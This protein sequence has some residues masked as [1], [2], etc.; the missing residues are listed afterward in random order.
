[1]DTP[2]RPEGST[3]R[4]LAADGLMLLVLALLVVKF[5]WDIDKVRDVALA[6]ETVYLHSGYH[7]LDRGFPAPAFSPLYALWYFLLSCLEPDPLRLYFLSWSVLTFL[8]AAGVY[9]L[10]RSLGGTRAAGLTAGFL[11]LTSQIPEVSPYP[12]YLATVLLLFGTVLAIR[13]RGRAASVAVLAATLLLTAFVRPEF[14]FAF[15]LLAA[16]G[17]GAGLW[18]A[19]R[20]PAARFPLLKAAFPVVLAAAG[21]VALF[22]NPFGGARSFIAFGQHYARN[23]LL[24]RHDSEPPWSVWES[25]V[26]GDFG[27]AHSVGA[28]VRNNPRAFAWHVGSNVCTLPRQGLSLTIPQLHVSQRDRRIFQGVLVVAG[29]VG[30]V[31]LWW[32]LA[33]GR[34][35]DAGYRG[36]RVTLVMLGFLLATTAASCLVVYPRQHYLLPGVTFAYALLAS[37]LS[38][39]AQEGA[40]WRRWNSWP[41]LA[42]LSLV[43]LG[44]MPNHAHTWDLPALLRHRQDARVEVPTIRPTARALRQL[45]LRRPV[46]VLELGFSWSFYAGLPAARVAA[47]E[48]NEGFRSFLRDKGIDVVIVSEELCRYAKYRDDPEFQEFLSGSP[49]EDFTFLSVEGTGVRIAVRGELL[50]DTNQMGEPGM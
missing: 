30:G 34:P 46:V 27:D 14:A 6:D 16:A 11:L 10:V 17:T 20:Q 45:P 1:M 21:L 26:A 19:W 3:W 41:V 43:L 44:T 13:W 23:V 40:S 32:R 29:L 35:E 37:C 8:L 4:S 42:A 24:S 47:Q 12:T 7:L 39:T 18:V 2:S 36:L 49:T 50:R 33:R 31:G 38:R 48:K 15:L 28:A 9:A 5:T 25:V 22:G